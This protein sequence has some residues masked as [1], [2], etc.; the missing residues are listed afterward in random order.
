[1]KLEPLPENFVTT[2]QA[3]H[4]IAF[5]AIAPARYKATGRMGLR[6]TP[7]G[8]GTPEFEGKVARVEGDQLVHSQ[9]GNVATQTIT[10]IREAAQFFGV[11]YEAEWFA[12]F[13]DPLAPADPDDPLKTSLEAGLALGAWFSFG[14]DVLNELRSHGTEDDD[15]SEVQLW[16][17]HFDPATELGDYEKGQRT[18]YGASPGDADH[19]E[20]YL[21]VASWSEV[22]RSNPYWNDP[23]F[24]GASLGYADL[25]SSEDPAKRAI[26][27]LLQGYRQLTDNS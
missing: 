10:T 5:F 23:F 18:S 22:D 11:D 27:F 15:I 8:F 19:P 13:H 7:G 1:M 6:A 26:E 4:Q 3:L 16:P 9:D 24:G 12:D 14:T 25:L 20:P 17:E 2:R 21:F